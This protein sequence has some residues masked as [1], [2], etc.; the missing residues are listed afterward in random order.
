MKRLK[1]SFRKFYG[2]YG[3]LIQQYEVSLSRMLNNILTLDQ[4]QWLPNWSDSPPIFMTLI[5]DLT[6]TELRVVSMKHLQWVWLASRERLLF[7]TPGSVPLLGE[8]LM[9]QLLRPVL[10]NLPYLNIDV[11]HWSI[12]FSHQLNVYWTDECFD[13]NRHHNLT[14]SYITPCWKSGPKY[15]KDLSNFWLVLW[16]A[17]C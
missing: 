4:L 16:V 9:R 17:G 15:H 13:V 7:R 1:S 10:L 3:Y 14:K 8:L 6:F 11:L 5:P 2:R 12:Q